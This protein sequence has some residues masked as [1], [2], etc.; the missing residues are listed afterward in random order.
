MEITYVDQKEI[1]FGA[2]ESALRDAAEASTVRPRPVVT[3]ETG[4][5]E[6]SMY[7]FPLTQIFW[8]RP[9]GCSFFACPPSSFLFSPTFLYFSVIE[10]DGKINLSSWILGLSCDRFGLSCD[11]LSCDRFG[12]SCDS[13]RVK[14][15]H[16][17][18]NPSQDRVKS[19]QVRYIYLSSWMRNS[20]FEEFHFFG[21]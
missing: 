17:R 2:L 16:V 3:L 6:G 21:L 20:V 12:W 18:V 5:S 1:T 14:L 11:M 9:A 4:A 7:P 19:C 13:F 15:W 8:R 10:F